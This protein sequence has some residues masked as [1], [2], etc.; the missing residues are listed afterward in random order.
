MD[1]YNS[2]RSEVGREV[3]DKLNVG[4]YYTDLVGSELQN[5]TM[6]ERGS[7]SPLEVG[8]NEEQVLQRVKLVEA[9]VN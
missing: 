2:F 5:G 7:I 9:H 4:K 8:H 1:H 6:V 3:L